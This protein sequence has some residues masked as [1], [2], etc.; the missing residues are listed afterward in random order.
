MI[1]IDFFETIILIIASF[2][3]GYIDAVVG[4]GGLIQFPT[5]SILYPN[6][7][8][9]SLF[10]TN[11]LSSFT[12]T[13]IAGFKYAKNVTVDY[14][15]IVLVGVFAISFSIIGAKVVSLI[16]PNTLK[17]FILVLLIAIAVY[18]YKKKDFGQARV[19][20]ISS[21]K[22]YFFGMLIGVFI[23]FY[24]GFFGPGTGGFFTM[25]FVFLL[26]LSFLEASAY[27]K[28]LNLITNLGALMVFISN[29]DLLVV[30][31]FTMLLFNSLGNYFGVNQALKKGNLFIRKVFLF[32]VC[33]LII[34]YA[35][36]VFKSYI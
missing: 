8:L 22:K 13:L 2:F 15:I 14:K 18:T 12:G 35:Y 7:N 16:N 10:G 4:G 31:A 24:D 32:V 33:M 5:L 29:R 26:G 17:P 28:I 6:S 23:G 36:D 1:E 27:G 3:A 25:S 34:R 19:K 30:P 20:N 11:K 21:Q 9:A